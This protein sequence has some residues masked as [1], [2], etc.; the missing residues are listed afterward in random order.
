MRVENQQ[1][2]DDS[3]GYLQ[4]YAILSI[5]KTFKT[6]KSAYQYFF[7]VLAITEHISG[8]QELE[9]DEPEDPW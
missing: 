5:Y 6:N 2:F 7:M 9:C 3:L 8:N 4:K 1:L